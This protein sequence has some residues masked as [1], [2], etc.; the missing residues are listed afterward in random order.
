MNNGE[1]FEGPKD[2]IKA[3]RVAKGFTNQDDFADDIGIRRNK[4]KDFEAGR[5]R[6]TQEL[7]EKIH[8]KYGVN[9]NWFYNGSGAMFISSDATESSPVAPSRAISHDLRQYFTTSDSISHS[10]L[11]GRGRPWSV[12][13]AELPIGAGKVSFEECQIIGNI[14]LKF[15]EQ[16]DYAMR[17]RGTSM[18]PEIA[19]KALLFIKAFFDNG[20]EVH[21]G[22]LIVCSI[23]DGPGYPDWMVRRAYVHRKKELSEIILEANNGTAETIPYNDEHIFCFGKVVDWVNDQ[24]RIEEIL[25]E[26]IEHIR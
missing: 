14:I 21:N 16:V 13:I 2:R 10:S 24:E 5:T 23:I 12:D 11:L 3:V 8:H 7:A 1:D 19:D 26:A 15:P 18:E 20:H 25:K 17:V 22:D 4:I 6:I 9:L